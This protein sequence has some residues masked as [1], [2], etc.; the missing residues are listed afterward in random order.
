MPHTESCFCTGNSRQH[1][2][3]DAEIGEAIHERVT[4]WWLD[5]ACDSYCDEGRG[6]GQ[7]IDADWLAEGA[8]P[9]GLP[10]AAIFGTGL[11]VT[12]TWQLE[13]DSR[14]MLTVKSASTQMNTL[15]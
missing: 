14:S 5:R 4:L 3:P 10:F 9:L 1:R 6:G 2:L 12:V 13:R 11:E 8:A 15:G 7:K